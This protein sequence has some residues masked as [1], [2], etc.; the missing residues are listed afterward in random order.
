MIVNTNLAEEIIKSAQTSLVNYNFPSSEDYRLKL[1]YNDIKRGSNVLCNIEKELDKCDEFWFSVAFITE[2]GLLMLKNVL[3]ELSERGIKGRILTTDY[4]YFNTP[5]SFRE[6]LKLKN[7]ESKVYTKEKFHTKGYMFKKKAEYTFIIGSSNL[8]QGALKENKEWN[9]K[10]SSLEEG[11]LI[12]ETNAEFEM[13]WTDADVL[14]ADWIREY[15]IIFKKKNELRKANKIIRIKTHT[16]KPNIMQ[17]EAIENLD[18]LRKNREK[19]ALLIS[20]TG[21]GKTY[22][23]AFDVRNYQ[24]S[25]ML[26]LVHREQ[27]LKQALESYKDVLGE[28]IYAA[29]LSGNDKNYDADYLFSTV[30]MMS[31]PDILKRFSATHFDYIC[32]DETHRSGAESY[33]RIINYFNPKFLL[34]MTASPERSDGFD[35]Y[36]IF[37]HNI[38]YEIRLQRALEEN[39][40]CPFHYFGVTDLMINGKGIDDVSEFQYLLSEERVDNIISKIEYYGYS[41]DR[42]RGLI[43]C[44]RKDEAKELSDIF[45]KRGYRTVALTGDDR[46][47]VREATIEKLEVEDR[48]GGLD[49][50]FT[51]DIFNE[52]IDIP[53]INQVVMLR[54]TESAI[55]FI[56]QLG[57]GLRKYTDKEYVVV[58]DFIGNYTK[59]FL[60]P[61]ALSGDRTY[62]KDSI[63]RYIGEGNRIIPGSSTINFDEISK[64]RIFD[65]IDSVNFSDIKLI[66]ESYKSLKHKLGRIPSLIDFDNYGEID[67]L[68]IFDNQSLGSYY[69][70]LVKYEEEYKVRLSLVQEK[71]IEFICK[72]F[73]SGKR[74]HELLLLK[75]LLSY[76]HGLFGYLKNKLREEYNIELSSKAQKNIINIMTNEFPTGTGKV[77]YKDCI[78]ISKENEDFGINQNFS[79]LLD[80]NE[81]RKIISEIIEFG[82]MRYKKNYSN[83]Y[84]D[85]NFQLYA[86]YTYEDVCRLL[87]WEKAEVALNIG[88]YKYDSKT[89]TYPIFINYE[90]NEDIQDTIR[91]E[92]RFINNSTLIAISKSGR[93][94]KSED[95]YTAIHAE[96]LKVDME[97]FVRKNKNDKGSKEFY[98][99]GKVKATGNAKE[100]IMSNTSKTAVEIEYQLLTP[101][102]EDLFDYI[103]NC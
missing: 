59:N 71:Y 2:G 93:T 73:A 99:L 40:L 83:R 82:L 65:S 88:G 62:N 56:Q 28:S 103:V 41:G 3:N 6:L 14:D 81:F 5:K 15:E 69:K 24:P 96:E 22:L 32:I 43:F 42:V 79:E 92:D 76:H 102:R 8:T 37:D 21:T 74:I 89:K 29:I 39:M 70:F 30:Q 98:F 13:L 77:T 23:S 68:R 100:F 90:K 19:K 57:R 95:V 18:L 17:K 33:Q 52:G 47:E 16:L 63:R 80:D 44:S 35:I 10:V 101:I 58:I 25:K 49:Y 34:G 85:T 84:M 7:I 20:A 53:C 31:K 86:K 48:E 45:N 60:I 55:I 26:F 64:K 1:L 54:P 61:I 50:I 72:K 46:P 66:K 9:M 36:Q 67:V 51:V 12:K 94:L 27:I 97:L 38:A 78:L 11:E 4:Q 87:E 91:Y 75:R